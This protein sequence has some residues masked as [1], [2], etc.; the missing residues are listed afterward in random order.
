MRVD[1]FHP[2]KLAPIYAQCLIYK[3]NPR[4]IKLYRHVDFLTGWWSGEGKGSARNNRA[5]PVTP[6]YLQVTAVKKERHQ[7]Y[8]HPIHL[9]RHRFDPILVVRR[10]G[11]G[12]T[13]D[14]VMPGSYEAPARPH[15]SL[16]CY[17]RWHRDYGF[18][19]LFRSSENSYPDP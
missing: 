5:E 9:Q 4:R 3:A 8:P 11:A 13:K 14:P 7:R 17:M 19:T 2:G 18:M 12:I 1:G 16:T 10:K 15:A 6:T